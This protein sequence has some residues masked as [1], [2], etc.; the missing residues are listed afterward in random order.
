MED[1]LDVYAQEP[2]PLRPRLC[3]DE[4][5][6]LMIGDVT[7][8]IA[9][10]AGK[11]KKI[12]YEYI[13]GQAVVA[14]LAYNMDTGQRHVLISDTK[15][16]MD[17]A[18]YFKWLLDTH[19]P[20]AKGIKLIQDNLNTHTKGS[21]YKAFPPKEAREL[22]KKIE[23]HFTPKHGS[24][25]NMAEMEFAALSTQCLSRRISDKE[26]FVKEVKAWEVRRN[27]KA[28]KINWSFTIDLAQEK[29]KRHYEIVCKKEDDLCQ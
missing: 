4:R 27:A 6:C 18:T 2:D 29:F 28:T 5:P 11:P 7:S 8:P 10:K 22:V 21:F 12:D 3:F 20:N 24:W 14:L 15:T 26:T 17:Y 25:L 13:H 16:K 9:M 23:F 19:Y 1:I